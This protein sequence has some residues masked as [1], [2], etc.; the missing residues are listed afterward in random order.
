MEIT[1]LSERIKRIKKMVELRR[2]GCELTDD[3]LRKNDIVPDKLTS[4][5][6]DIAQFVCRAVG[7]LPLETVN[8]IIDD[9]ANEDEVLLASLKY[10]RRALIQYLSGEFERVIRDMRRPNIK[11]KFLGWIYNELEETRME[12]RALESYDEPMY[13][14]MIAGDKEV[15]I[16]VDK[17]GYITDIKIINVDI[18]EDISKFKTEH[19][20]YDIHENRGLSVS[21]LERFRSSGDINN[22]F[23]AHTFDINYSEDTHEYYLE[24][25]TYRTCKR[26]DIIQS[27][28]SETKKCIDMKISIEYNEEEK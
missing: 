8:D 9:V 25:H 14:D 3:E 26:V 2:A 5:E 10:V 27:I 6:I 21:T 18:E 17:A 4:T 13:I 23:T 22:P 7:D 1:L 20:T 15:Y 11:T 19:T 28:D 12:I 24:M 16:N